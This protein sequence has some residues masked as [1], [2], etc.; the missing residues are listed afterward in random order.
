MLLAL[1]L[2]VYFILLTGSVKLFGR[3][4]TTELILL[5]LWALMEIM[6]L[7]VLHEAG[8]LAGAAYGLTWAAVA[9]ASLI[10]F[11][12]YMMYYRMDDNTAYITG[13]VPLL[14]DG[15]VTLMIALL[16]R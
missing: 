15:A 2:L 10:A 9:V 8:A 4:P 6:V 5:V 12:A 13:A 3:K 14:A 16:G 1:A 11:A 7:G